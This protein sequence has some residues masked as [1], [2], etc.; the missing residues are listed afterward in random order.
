MLVS[1]ITGD[2]IDELLS[3]INDHLGADDDALTI[4]LGP[5]AGKLMHWLHE[6][7]QVMS[8]AAQ[9]NGDQLLNVRVPSDKLVRLRA[10]WKRAGL[11]ADRFSETAVVDGD[12]SAS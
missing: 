7:A 2:G 6:N 5:A 4:T 10:E 9:D 3:T 8:R 1:A 12:S 11:A